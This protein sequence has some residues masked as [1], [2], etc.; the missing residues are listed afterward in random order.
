MPDQR[1]TG[2]R[3][4]ITDSAE[5]PWQLSRDLHAWM[6]A[7]DPT[8]TYPTERGP[9]VTLEDAAEGTLLVIP[10][11]LIATLARGLIAAHVDSGRTD[12]WPA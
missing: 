2:V 11:S 8:G 10:N 12:R 1:A 5:H 3:H 7:A 6:S 9:F 4:P